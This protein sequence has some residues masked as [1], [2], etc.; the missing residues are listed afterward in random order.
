MY[1][2]DIPGKE[3][4][5]RT[6]INAVEKERIPHAQIFLAKEGFGGLPMALAYAS[7]IMCENKNGVDSCGECSH[8]RKSHKRIHPDIHFSFPVVKLGDKKREITTSDDY[9]PQW[10]S[11]LDDDKFMSKSDW[12]D[13]IDAENRQPNINV[14][15]CNDIM[16]KLN[17]MS[18]ESD[19][20]ILI[21][22]LPEYLGNEG[23][24]LLKL[25]EEPTD[26][27]F[28]ILVAE[29][30]EHIL[31]TILSRCQLVK[32][33][34]FSSAE[35][36][37]F[38]VKNQ[39]IEESKAHQIANLADGNLN[40]AIHI[41]NNDS[42]DYS[43][44]L[45]QWL[46]VAYKSDPIEINKWVDKVVGLPKEEQKNFLEYGLHFFRQ[47]NFRTQ[48]GSA[49][50]NLTTQELDIVAKMSSIITLEKS[51]KIALIFNDAIDYISRNANMKIVLF[52]DSI[53]IGEIMRN[54][55]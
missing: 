20:K 16:Q 33:P 49:E 51:E 36:R 6:L 4:L 27:T 5:K 7:Y 35:I 12:L 38:L 47:Y 40:L 31:Q 11:I 2:R 30:Q 32:I 29:N 42:D 25:I 41:S 1:F 15:E 8:C 17:M 9:L 14:K 53:S 45:I 10:R 43:E 54:K 22:W 39:D 28:I 3:N 34:A 21:M 48:T 52:A 50:V 44:L 55:Y 23:N 26:N 19:K 46:R 37:E 18:Y 24:R 13:Y